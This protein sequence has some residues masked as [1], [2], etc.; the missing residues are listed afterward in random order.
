MLLKKM[1]FEFHWKQNESTG[2]VLKC[3]AMIW[4]TISRNWCV[5]FLLGSGIYIPPATLT[6]IWQTALIHSC[7]THAHSSKRKSAVKC[8]SRCLR[9]LKGKTPICLNLE[10]NQHT[11]WCF[12][13]IYPWT[14]FF[15]KNV[16]ICSP[17]SHRSAC[18]RMCVSHA[19]MSTEQSFM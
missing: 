11:M 7:Q 4:Q 12:L 14:P 1:P 8:L 16:Q 15:I 5:H 17:G 6:S 10:L 18:V 9:G 19:V 13:Q 3:L 2:S